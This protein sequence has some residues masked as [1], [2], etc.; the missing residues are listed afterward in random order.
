MTEGQQG[1]F[2]TGLSGLPEGFRYQQELIGPEDEES[3]VRQIEGLPFANFQ[4]HGF[5]GKRRVVSFGWRYDFTGGGLQRTDPVPGFLIPLRDV[6][7][8]FATLT[9]RRFSTRW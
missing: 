8:R 5:E 6:A 7:A 2:E 3:L 9:L 1:L 4:F